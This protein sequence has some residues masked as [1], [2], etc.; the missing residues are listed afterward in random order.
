MAQSTGGG[1][2]A[3]F[4]TEVRDAVTPQATLLVIG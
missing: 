2:T 1:A 3:S 4:L